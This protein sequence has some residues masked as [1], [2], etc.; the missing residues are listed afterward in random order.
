MALSLHVTG[1]PGL[2]FTF[3]PIC[4]VIIFKSAFAHLLLFITANETIH[5]LTFAA[6]RPVLT[7]SCWL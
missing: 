3:G 1:G 4:C 5:F 2:K 7:L 6:N